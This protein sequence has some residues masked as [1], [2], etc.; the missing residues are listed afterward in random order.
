[1]PQPKTES[2]DIILKSETPTSIK[3][4]VQDSDRGILFSDERPKPISSYQ[5]MIRWTGWEK[6]SYHL[7]IYQNE[8]LVII[9]EIKID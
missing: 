5:G 3:V 8:K 1:M 6:G 4:V 9:K 2:L 7:M